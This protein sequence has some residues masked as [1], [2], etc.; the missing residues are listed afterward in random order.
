MKTNAPEKIYLIRNISTPTSLNT[1]NDCHEKYLQEWYKEREKDAD[2]E[3]TRTDA[4]IEKASKWIDATFHE[5]SIDGFG[6]EIVDVV[7]SEI[8]V[9]KDDLIKDFINYMKGE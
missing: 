9:Y 7:M 3:Y 5:T 8:S 2:I 6:G 4:F 1:T